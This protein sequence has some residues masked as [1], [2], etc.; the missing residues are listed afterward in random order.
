MGSPGSS[1]GLDS[2]GVYYKPKEVGPPMQDLLY[3]CIG[4]QFQ[5]YLLPD[6]QKEALISCVL[7]FCKAG[8]YKPT[9]QFLRLLGLKTVNLL[10]VK[11]ALLR[12]RPI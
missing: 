8:A 4:G 12:M 6:P 1:P 2:G 9:Y 10:V 11:Y 5:R 7:S 3:I